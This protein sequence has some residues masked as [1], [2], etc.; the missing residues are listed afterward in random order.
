MG[1]DS[2]NSVYIIAISVAAALMLVPGGGNSAFAQ[3]ALPAV[4]GNLTHLPPPVLEKPV[5]STVERTADKT[6][7]T[8]ES[9]AKT[10][11]AAKASVT[12]TATSIVRDAGSAAGGLLRQFIPSTDPGGAV[13]EQDV[14]VVLAEPDDVAGLPIPD[15]QL[16]TRRELPALGLTLLTLRRP[17]GVELPQAIENVRSAFPTSAVDFNHVYRYES[18]TSRPASVLPG[19]PRD[20]VATGLRVG[21][22]DSAVEEDHPALAGSR[23]VARD[24]ATNEGIR[25][26]THGTAVASLVTG[27]AGGTATIYS[28]SV[29]FQV[30][31][32]EPGA[33]TE[34][35]VA[36]LEWM[37]EE[38]VPVVNMS[39]A[40][41]GNALLEKA[42][43]A[44][45]ARG[46]IVVAAVGNNGP[47][48]PPLFPAA[49]DGV[50][51]VTAVDHDD[52][53]FR[54]ANRGDQVDCA[55]AGV[56]LRVAD[57]ESGGWILASGTSMASPHVAVVVARALGSGT[58]EPASVMS[59]L[60]ANARD[61]GARGFDPVFGYGLITDPPSVA[62]A[63][64]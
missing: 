42:I 13:I 43:A 10:V 40:G 7:D 33:T 23:V 19:P 37:A 60:V 34:S 64:H 17:T 1:R 16:L 62:S 53:I 35:L 30:P 47:S 63:A 48:G 59:W 18:E 49:Y 31:N 39:L 11:D 61:L 12:D 2:H 57:S 51:G 41:P 14:I 29:F 28:A 3:I 38:R 46:L 4:P 26:R 22:V 6:K 20:E 9:A 24:F 25:P 27:S 36:A 50:I 55:A 52:R 32:H 45:L 54:Y 8:T 21:M 44:T 15:D 5:R 56:D 58:I